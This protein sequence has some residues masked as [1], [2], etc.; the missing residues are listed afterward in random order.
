M[1]PVLP[2]GIPESIVRTTRSGS[3]RRG[4]APLFFL[5][6]IRTVQGVDPGPYKARGGAFAAGRGLNGTSRVTS[7]CRGVRSDER[8]KRAIPM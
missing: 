2:T 3:A 6:G 4:C 5:N 7:S 1:R 8:V